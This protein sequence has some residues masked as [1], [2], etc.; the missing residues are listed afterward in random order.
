MSPRPPSAPPVADE[1]DASVEGLEDE[2]GA[3]L[4]DLEEVEGLPEPDGPAPTV[5]SFDIGEVLIDESRVWSCWADVLGVT[6]LTFAAVLGA[7]IAQGADYPDVFAHVAPNV[8][9]H[10]FVDE[11]ERRYGGFQPG[12][13]YADAML[14]LSELRELGFRVVVVGNQPA[15]RR[16][17]LES[18][19]LPADVIATSG[20]LGVAKP[21]PAFFDRLLQ[22]A[23]T[24]DPTDVLY[25]GDRVDNDVLPALDHGMHACWVRRGPYGALQELPE[26]AEPDFV[27]DG[28]GELPLLMDQ[29]RGA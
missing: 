29:W 9:W 16:R 27:L 28:L 15:Q 3:E 20:E 12:D 26:G 25:V 13:V 6:P 5:V 7:A 23:D 24:T 18:L 10:A 21:D 19:G 2:Y 1:L 8:D 22:L 4:G 17:Q 11:H 14:C